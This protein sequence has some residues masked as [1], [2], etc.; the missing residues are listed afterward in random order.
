MTPFLACWLGL[1]GGEAFRE[2]SFG[3]P[4]GN[5]SLEASVGLCPEYTEGNKETRGTHRCAVPQV[6]RALGR[7]PSSPPRNLLVLV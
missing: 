7:L 6:L 3:L 2:D 4:V 5:P 1:G